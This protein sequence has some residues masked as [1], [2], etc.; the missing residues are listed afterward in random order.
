MSVDRAVPDQP[1]PGSRQ[2]YRE[3]VPSPSLGQPGR[4]SAERELGLGVLDL[5]S[6]AGRDRLAQLA[7]AQDGALLQRRAVPFL[8]GLE[9]VA[10]AERGARDLGRHQVD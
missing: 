10:A 6:L 7:P 9:A 4:Q 3:L 1:I 8:G 2:A 5:A